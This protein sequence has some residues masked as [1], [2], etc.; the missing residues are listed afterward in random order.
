M[1]AICPVAE[2]AIHTVAWDDESDVAVVFALAAPQPPCLFINTRLVRGA[3]LGL[4]DVWARRHIRL[5][6]CFEV[7]WAHDLDVL[8]E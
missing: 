6:R 3:A 8:R 5:G 1:F 7:I 4:I 2:G